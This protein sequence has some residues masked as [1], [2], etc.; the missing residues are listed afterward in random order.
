MAEHI[1][2]LWCEDCIFFKCYGTDG[3]GECEVRTSE[4]VWYAHPICSYFKEKKKEGLLYATIEEIID[5]TEV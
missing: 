1:E 2:P 4:D 3:E 5:E